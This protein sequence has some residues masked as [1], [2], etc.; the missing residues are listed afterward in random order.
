MRYTLILAIIMLA[1]ASSGCKKEIE[2]I[3][4]PPPPETIWF[5][6]VDSVSGK[7]ALIVM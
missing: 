7:D 6:L 3:C 2:D 1:V 4:T 5:R